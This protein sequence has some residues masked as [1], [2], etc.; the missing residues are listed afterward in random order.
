MKCSQELLDKI[1]KA[2]EE[3]DYGKVTI[4]TAEKGTFWEIIVE[5]KER[6]PK[7]DAPYKQG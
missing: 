7:D 3:T 4:T 1:Q 6:I 2:I 5:K